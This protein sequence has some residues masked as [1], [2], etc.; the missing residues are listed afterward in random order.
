MQRL[1]RRDLRLGQAR[2]AA[3][4]RGATQRLRLEFRLAADRIQHEQIL[5][6]VGLV[7]GLQHRLAD[8]FD[9]RRADPAFTH[10]RQP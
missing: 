8:E 6:A 1:D 2:I 7:A 4:A 3:L 9:L 10:R 5:G